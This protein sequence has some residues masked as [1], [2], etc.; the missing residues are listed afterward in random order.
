MGKRSR[1]SCRDLSKELKI[2]PFILQYML[3]LLSFVTSNKDKFITNSDQYIIYTRHNKDLYFPQ[4]NLATYQKEV[5]Y[6]GVKI[7]SN[8]P[9]DIKSASGK[10]K[11]FKNLLIHFLSTFSFYSLEEYYNR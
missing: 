6:S 8:L 1:D 2:L 7:F 11:R 9:S 10:T 5:H 3:S 4:A